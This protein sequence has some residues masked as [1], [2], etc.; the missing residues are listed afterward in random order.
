MG[1]KKLSAKK[2]GTFSTNQERGG[3]ESKK[4]GGVQDALLVGKVSFREDIKEGIE[5]FATA[6]IFFR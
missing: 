6:N 4:V 2:G 1:T 5:Y 3:K